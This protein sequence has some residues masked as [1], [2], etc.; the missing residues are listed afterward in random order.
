MGISPE[1]DGFDVLA[2]DVPGPVTFLNNSLAL[3][4]CPPD[5]L[6]NITQIADFTRE[7]D[8]GTIDRVFDALHGQQLY[9]EYG[10]P[11][12]P[13]EDFMTGAGLG[14]KP[15]ADNLDYLHFIPC[16]DMGAAQGIGELRPDIFI[17]QVGF[18]RLHHDAAAA[19]VGQCF[20]VLVDI[21]DVVGAGKIDKYIIRLVQ[22]SGGNIAGLLRG[23]GK[24]PAGFAKADHIGQLGRHDRFDV[25]A[26]P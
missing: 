22:T 21:F 7:I 1:L 17:I 25:P 23:D 9:Q 3:S 20:D 13:L 4:I 6:F 11:V 24:R 19:K 16:A 18:D 26:L 8:Q 10:C 14:I 2:L 5:H 15:V 12:K